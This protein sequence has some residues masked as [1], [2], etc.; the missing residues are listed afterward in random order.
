MQTVSKLDL[1]LF[2]DSARLLSEYDEDDIIDLDTVSPSAECTFCLPRSDCSPS[3][4]RGCWKVDFNTAT[5]CTVHA[6]L[7]K[8]LQHCVPEFFEEESPGACLQD[9]GKLQCQW[10]TEIEQANTGHGIDHSQG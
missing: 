6:L 8:T 3:V 10:Y 5:L 4:V 9:D 1:N 7:I 2:A